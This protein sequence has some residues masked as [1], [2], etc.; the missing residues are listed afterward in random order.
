MPLTKDKSTPENEEYWRFVEKTAAEV[1]SWPSWKTGRPAAPEG[2]GRE[3]PPSRNCPP[4]TE[5]RER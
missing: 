2:R 4:P 1:R 5:T 3:H